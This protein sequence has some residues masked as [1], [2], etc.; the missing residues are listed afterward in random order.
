[1]GFRAGQWAWLMASVIAGFL[2]LVLVPAT[3]F[4]AQLFTRLLFVAIPLGTLLWL[5]GRHASALFGRMSAGDA[6]VT[7][8]AAVLSILSALLAALVVQRFA[9]VAPNPL[10]VDAA[11]M[12]APDL[13]LNLLSTAPQL[14]GE[15]LLTILPFLALLRWTSV[16]FGLA[17]RYAIALALLGSTIIFCAAHLPTYHW[18][19][20][21][22]FG[23]IGASRVV[24]T[25]AYIVTRKLWVPAGAHIL[26]DWTEFS[27]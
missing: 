6:G 16:K 13:V 23:V 19:W 18:N 8:L 7:A 12:S 26:T 17:R 21:Q 3:S 27:T 11:R 5:A 4:Q 20:A 14:L 2:L 15:E 25:S 22:C 24:L 10:A 9:P 1:M